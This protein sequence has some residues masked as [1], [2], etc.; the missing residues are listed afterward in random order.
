[1]AYRYKTYREILTFEE[2]KKKIKDALDVLYRLNAEI[3]Y[4]LLAQRAIRGTEITQSGM[5]AFIRT[6]L[7]RQDRDEIGIPTS[8]DVHGHIVWYDK[9]GRRNT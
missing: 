2:K 3:S 7:T 1:M 9:N 5:L 8:R 6:G 4:P